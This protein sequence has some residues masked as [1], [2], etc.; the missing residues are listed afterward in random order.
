VNGDPATPAH[1]RA[2]MRLLSRL[3]PPDRYCELKNRPLGVRLDEPQFAS[4]V[5]DHRRT[6]REPQSHTAGLCRKE[7]VEDVLSI[8]GSNSGSGV[9]HRQPHGRVTVE[10]RCEPQTS[11]FRSHGAHCVDRVLEEVQQYLL[12]LCAI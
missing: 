5:F 10:T 12:E 1:L 6:D 4:V 7:R 8:L 3:L 2:N 9:L 11:F